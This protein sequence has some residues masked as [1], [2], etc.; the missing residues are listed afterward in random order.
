VESKIKKRR[1]S[2]GTNEKINYKDFMDITLVEPV[3]E[4]SAEEEPK[5][6]L[7]SRSTSI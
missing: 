4:V 5:S 6:Y 3:R 7:T 1:I 2:C